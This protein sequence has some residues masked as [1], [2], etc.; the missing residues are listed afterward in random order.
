MVDTPDPLYAGEK[1]TYL[2][3][4]SNT[5][6][7]DAHGIV[8]TDTLPAGVILASAIPSQ[9][10]CDNEIVCDLGTILANSS[11]SITLVVTTTIDGLITNKASV[12]SLDYDQNIADNT[13]QEM[14]TV[15]PSADISV[16]K[17]ENLEPSRLD[18]T[19]AYI[20]T[21]AYTLTVLN[22]GPSLAADVILTDT[23]PTTLTLTSAVTEQGSCKG[24]NPVKCDLGTI[25]I[26]SR[27][28]VMIYVIPTSG[29][30]FTSTVNIRSVAYDPDLANNTTQEVRLVDNTNP[31]VRWEKPVKDLEYYP[32]KSGWVT[33][34]A[35]AEDELFPNYPDQIN[36]LVF[37]WW[38]HLFDGDGDGKNEGRFVVIGTDTQEPYQV[39]FDSNVLKQG[40][41][42]QIYAYAYDRAGN[43][44]RQR[45]FFERLPI[46]FM[47]IIIR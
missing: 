22:E 35:S 41:I 31:V 38:D 4:V 12:G 23:L 19:N 25:D 36:Q 17:V 8:L 21:I 47:P 32:T 26:D 20:E 9:G 43:Y 16:S 13:Y 7:T 15:L 24:P 11:A 46:V 39:E 6:S 3:T 42:Y 28:K 45:I 40:D 10:A 1:I 18:K 37:K 30:V 27:V 44:G 14:A 33:L 5:R 29:G 2:M 34:E